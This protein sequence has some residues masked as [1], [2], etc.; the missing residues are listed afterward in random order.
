MTTYVPVGAA[1]APLV[2]GNS[3]CNADA[4]SSMSNDTLATACSCIGKPVKTTTFTIYSTAPAVKQTT[5]AVVA[6]TAATTTLYKIGRTTRTTTVAPTSVVTSSMTAWT[7]STHTVSMAAPTFKPAFGPKEGCVDTAA[8]STKP[9][10]SRFSNMVKAVAECKRLCVQKA[11]C[12][13][14]YV[15]HLMAN[16]GSQLAYCKCYFNDH[17]L[18]AT[19]DLQCGQ[20]EVWG[21]AVGYNACSRGTVEL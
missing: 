12:E 20:G 2:A 11:D 8:V 16:H 21:S 19:E 3:S 5:T 6:G 1:N 15:Q 4:L 13:F 14:V 9:L 10:R 18:N 7:T 17:K